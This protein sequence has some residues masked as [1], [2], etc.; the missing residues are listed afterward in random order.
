MQNLARRSRP[1][2]RY[3]SVQLQKMKQELQQG[4]IS[5]PFKQVSSSRPAEA[6][7]ARIKLIITKSTK[8][9]YLRISLGISE[10]LS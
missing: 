8:N 4:I 2:E 3:S 5:V 1:S 10:L 9:A 7:A 6:G